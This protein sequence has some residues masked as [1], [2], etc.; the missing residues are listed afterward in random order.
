MED[1]KVKSPTI[2]ID[3]GTTYSCIG[4]WDN[5]KEDIT[6]IPNS[7]GEKTTPSVVALLNENDRIVGKEA[8]EYINN[9]NKIEYNVL[10]DSKRLI[11]R[12]FNEKVIEDDIKNWPFTIKEQKSTGK[13]VYEISIVENKNILDSKR[14]LFKKYQK[15]QTF[16]DEESI[17]TNKKEL[18][19]EQISAMILSQL[20]KDA[21]DYLGIKVTSAVI[22]VPAYFTAPQKEATKQAAEIARIK[23]KRI[24]NEPT[25]AALAY[26]FDKNI[27]INKNILVFDL[28]GGTFDVTILKL[29]NENGEKIFKTIGV[30][31]DNHLGGQD[32]DTKLMKELI[33]KFNK[34]KRTKLNDN[35][36]K[37]RLKR[38]CEKAKIELS[39]KEETTINLQ[40]FYLG[41]DFE[42]TITRKEFE[43]LCNEYFEKC[44]NIIKNLLEET[45]LKKDDINNII[46]IGG[47]SKIPKIK[48][49]IKNYFNLSEI[50]DTINPDEAVCK[51]ATIQSS[52]IDR[53]STKKLKEIKILDILPLSLGTN[54]IGD[55]MSI[56][57]EKGTHIPTTKSQTYY[58]VNDYQ[59]GISNLVYEGDFENIKDNHYLG[60]FS[61][62]ILPK[63]KGES[64]ILI[65]YNIDENYILTAKAVEI[66]NEN[67]IKQIII[68]N[69]R[70]NLTEEEINKFQK[71]EDNYVLNE[72]KLNNNNNYINF[73]RNFKY[74]SKF[75]HDNP[76][77]SEE[78][79]FNALFHLCTNLENF[80]SQMDLKN[81]KN[82]ITI[83][84]KL[85]I[86]LKEL[87]KFYSII[88]QYEDLTE[89]NI[90]NMKKTIMKYLDI[91]KIFND[92]NIYELIEDLKEEYDLYD[93][94]LLYAINYLNFQGN[95]KYEINDFENAL[96]YYNKA[97]DE[98]N[99][100]KDKINNLDKEHKFFVEKNYKEISNRIN[101]INKI[102]TI[103]ENIDKFNK[104]FAENYEINFNSEEDKRNELCNLIVQSLEL[105]HDENN[106]ILDKKSYDFC[107]D[108]YNELWNTSYQEFVS[109]T[110]ETPDMIQYCATYRKNHQEEINNFEELVKQK[111]KDVENDIYNKGLKLI[112]WLL[113]NYPYNGYDPNENFKLNF[114]KYPI[115]YFENLAFKYL[116]DK[117]PIDTEENRKYYIKIQIISQNLN[118]LNDKLENI[119]SNNINK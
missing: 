98:Y 24:I 90:L 48:E 107:K 67:N 33:I 39:E 77:E 96:N 26:G 92:I 31:G 50:N 40:N 76:N 25:A 19:P 101:N 63:K 97:I 5:E 66:N 22:T 72:K 18:I 1:K 95:K 84:E 28:G 8:K 53:N 43:K 99:L 89:E 114:N 10:Y 91:L 12:K 56:I 55:K 68:I 119:N 85:K 30:K 94:C 83:K 52:V 109:I 80:I 20:K 79:K 29:I 49:L 36:I 70:G 87:F 54:I 93:I 3:L 112:E 27:E 58:P 2:G 108:K 104:L 113:K 86:Y 14:E 11:G 60:D 13:A 74:Y 78:K 82:N 45:K 16:F 42:E 44:L 62:K 111:F 38:A 35:F 118:D 32:F 46:L 73:K 41:M 117:C 4:V 34:K 9:I 47:S 116:P 21:E 103:K 71:I 57:I 69:D 110:E 23:V 59:K 61:M 37:N 7:F 100:I 65:T 6:I 15:K 106:K 105:N 102:K 17:Y 88:C 115:K 81:I 64:K 51:G 75:L